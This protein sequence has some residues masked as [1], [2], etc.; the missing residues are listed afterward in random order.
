MRLAARALCVLLAALAAET[1]TA[2]AQ[3]P[4]ELCVPETARKPV[5]SPNSKG[6]CL[7]TKTVK[8]ETVSLP[9]AAEL[10][11]LDALLPHI[12]YLE[13]GVGGKP[14]VEFS[15]VNV[16][17]VNG[18]GRTAST[19]GAGN[20]VIGYD[21]NAGAHE[22]TGSHDL[23][24]GEEQAFTSYGGVLDGYRN[25]ITSPFA[26]VTGGEHNTASGK[27]S[28]VSGGTFGTA[29][30][31]GAAVSGGLGN[32]ASAYGDSVSG[33]RE[34]TAAGLE[35]NWIGGGYKNSIAGAAVR[36]T[37]IFGGKELLATAEYEAIP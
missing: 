9:G 37:S 15:G 1:G 33:G 32:H 36:R 24:L 8:Y 13:S 28:A 7:A 6:E 11:T 17:I 5:L 4:I 26:S 31:L 16:Q 34:S 22:Q 2:R 21:E 10:A 27:S 29:G 35:A 20:L 25:A 19:N 12:T 30:A 3:A 23:V 14:T 18:E